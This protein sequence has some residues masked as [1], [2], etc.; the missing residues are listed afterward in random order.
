[1]MTE[2]DYEISDMENKLLREAAELPGYDEFSIM[3][4]FCIFSRIKSSY[5]KKVQFIECINLVIQTIFL[6]VC[7][8]RFELIHAFIISI[9]MN[10]IINIGTR[11]LKER[12]FS[13]TRN[14]LVGKCRLKRY[15]K[16]IYVEVADFKPLIVTLK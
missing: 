5:M 13:Q 4:L 8:E 3:E 16:G 14:F 6:L 10:F 1:M 12:L 11:P 9:I 15:E 7:M 2:H